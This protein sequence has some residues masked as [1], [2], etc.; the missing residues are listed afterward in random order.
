MILY[1]LP[2]QFTQQNVS[3]RGNANDHVFLWPDVQPLEYRDRIF[4]SHWTNGFRAFFF[5]SS[6]ITQAFYRLISM[7]GVI[8]HFIPVWIYKT[9]K[10]KVIPLQ[11]RC[12]PEDG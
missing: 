3:T 8:L 1:L 9:C 6:S 2:S 11:A 12:G 10:G 5:V 7:Q 4:E